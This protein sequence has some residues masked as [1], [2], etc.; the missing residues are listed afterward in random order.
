[1]RTLLILA[2][3]YV[4]TA[5]STHAA[6]DVMAA[7]DLALRALTEENSIVKASSE[8]EKPS[9]TMESPELSG[10]TDDIWNQIVFGSNKS[11]ALSLP[12]PEREIEF[13][14]KYLNKIDR[15]ADKD[16]PIVQIGDLPPDINSGLSCLYQR[17]EQPRSQLIAFDP[18]KDEKV[19]SNLEWIKSSTSPDQAA[20]G[21][22]EGKQPTIAKVYEDSGYMEI[23][24]DLSYIYRSSSQMPAPQAET[25]PSPG[26]RDSQ[27][28]DLKE[29]LEQV[30][31]PA[32]IGK[33][34]GSHSNTRSKNY[35]IIVGINSYADRRGLHA[36]VNDANAIASILN[37]YGYDVIKLTDETPNKPTKH[38]I[39]K[40]ALAEVESKSDRDKV[41]F[42][43]SGHAVVDAKGDFYLIPQD[44]DG[45]P[46]SYICSEELS[47]YLKGIKN[48]AVIIDACNSGK[49]KYSL[50][51]GQIALTSSS[52]DEASNE[53][54]PGSFSV[55]TYQLCNAIKEERGQGKEI[56]LQRCFYI[57]RANTIEWSSQRLLKQTPEMIDMTGKLYYLN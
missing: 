25:K 21:E 36:S 22:A 18:I 34:Y 38:N 12:T 4:V 1:L 57:A 46:S 32:E 26:F 20:E 9:K 51:K 14:L 50:E 52:Q 7:S 28:V 43:F 13:N 30:H 48:L 23:E 15:H 24:A 29:S 5:Q 33:A 17:D 56:T 19:Q 6:E 42:Y 2:L 35:A 49:F 55:F 40:G 37:A 10:P 31:I 8:L 47:Q 44:A 53:E 39:L 3:I 41:I 45:E 11:N 54:W 16:K 27:T